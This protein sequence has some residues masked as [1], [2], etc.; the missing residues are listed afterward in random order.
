[1]VS[2]TGEGES[3]EKG[4]MQNMKILMAPFAGWTQIKIQIQNQIVG[5]AGVYVYMCVLFYS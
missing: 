5:I 3:S 2:A 1:M 4:H